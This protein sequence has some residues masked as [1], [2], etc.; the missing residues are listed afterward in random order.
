MMF[1]GDEMDGGMDGGDSGAPAMPAG[2][3]DAAG[4]DGGMDDGNGGGSM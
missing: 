1:D 4:N 2:G 3:D